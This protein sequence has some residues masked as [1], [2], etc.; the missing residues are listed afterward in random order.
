MQKVLKQTLFSTLDPVYRIEDFYRRGYPLSCKMVVLDDDPTGVQ[1]VH[2]V[3]VYTDWSV[4]S[5]CDGLREDG[6]IFFVLTNSRGVSAAQ[7]RAMHEQIVANLVEASRR[8]GVDFTIL[9]RSD[10]TLRGHYPLETATLRQGLIDAGFGDVDGE[11]IA[12]FFPEGGRYTVGDVHYVQEGDYLVPAGMTEFARDTTFGYTSSNLV[13]WVREKNPSLPAGARIH[14]IP[15]ELLRKGDVQG[16]CQRLMQARDFEKIIVNSADYADMEV[17]V[18]GLYLAMQAGKRFLFRVAAGLVRVMANIAPQ[19]LLAGAQLATGADV[20]GLVVVGSHVKKTTQ[21]LER[22]LALADVAPTEF[23]VTR[24]DDADAQAYIGRTAQK[25]RSDI[26]SGRTAVLYTSRRVVRRTADNSEE[27]LRFSLGVS[28]AL[29]QIVQDIGVMPAFIVAKG[30]ITSSDI[31]VKALKARRALVLGQ[32][33]PGIPVWK[34]G[35]ESRYPGV[36]YV[37]FPGNVG[38]ESALADV[39]SAAQRRSQVP[40]LEEQ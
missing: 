7:S 1:T 9:S 19:P 34:L 15:V 18:S 2:D 14:S 5:L 37:V 38:N 27:N 12:P 11:I 20:G 32:I 39:V 23:D 29:V 31:G 6:H 30:G 28:A 21:Q 4:Q 10:S 33:L 8:T 13:D 25:V 17:F 22:L 3:S 40:I 35:P 16:V 26:L 36:C 24:L